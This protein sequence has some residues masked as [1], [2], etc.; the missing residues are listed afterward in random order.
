MKIN[1]PLSQEDVNNAIREWTKNDSSSPS[2]LISQD[3]G[4]Y[5][6]GYYAGMGNSDST[7]IE[8]FEPLF[9]KTI[10]QL[11]QSGELKASGKE[12]TQYPGS[13]FFKKLE[14]VE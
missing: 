9:K 11:Y 8:K 1:Q 5:H 3:D 4:S 6:L 2:L 7:P 10:N 13:D 12:F 14:F